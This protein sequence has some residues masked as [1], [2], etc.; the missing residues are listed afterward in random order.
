MATV[1]ETVHPTRTARG[2]P[3][4]QSWDDDWL[5][6]VNETEQRLGH[7]ICGAHAPDGEPCELGSTH[8]NGRCRFHGG[9]P[10][11]GAQP[12]NTNALVHGL[13]SRRLRQCDATCPMWNACPFAGKDV[14]ELHPRKRPVCAFEAEA[15][16]AL[17]GLQ[18]ISPRHPLAAVPPTAELG[19]R[20]KPPDPG[21]SEAEMREQHDELV[22]AIRL[23]SLMPDC[24]Q[25]IERL[26]NEAC[27]DNG[28]NEREGG[29]DLPDDDDSAPDGDAPNPGAPSPDSAP[30]PK[31]VGPVADDA[32]GILYAMFQRASLYLAAHT[33]VDHTEAEG[34]RYS[35]RTTK[36][37]AGFT[38]FLRIAREL[39]A[40]LKLRSEIDTAH[41]D[42]AQTA[43]PGPAQQSVYE[44]AQT[45]LALLDI[46]IDTIVRAGVDPRPQ[47][48]ATGEPILD[49]LQ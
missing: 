45:F 40:W 48:D 5:A 28:T 18:S 9:H 14:M 10:R 38:A 29:T 39:R 7:R 4:A 19:T 8:P 27:A 41:T 36:V 37:G 13:Y 26:Q 33:I 44:S 3:R 25:R 11:I 46:A 49:D 42:S 6:L 16:A 35:M 17:S 20:V 24:Q 47:K 15:Y 30:H 43:T 31:S 1:A 23:H 34:E 21:L 32:A 2:T 22:R 12:G